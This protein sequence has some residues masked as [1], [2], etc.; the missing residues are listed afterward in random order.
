VHER[1]ALA[2]QAA[3]LVE[4]V[5][6]PLAGVLWTEG[7]QLSPE[8]LPPRERLDAIRTAADSALRAV[9]IEEGLFGDADPRTAASH[10]RLA[11]AR[12]I[13]RDID[14]NLD[15]TKA[16]PIQERG[17]RALTAA[18]ALGGDS[19]QI[20]KVKNNLAMLYMSRR[21][22]PTPSD[23]ARSVEL[24]Q[25]ALEGHRQSHGDTH[26]LF[27]N[28]LGNL[29]ATESRLQ[30]KDQAQARESI[31]LAEEALQRARE[32]GVARHQLLPLIMALGTLY[33]EYEGGDQGANAG[34]AIELGEEALGISDAH[35]GQ[36]SESG[37]RVRNNLGNAYRWDP[38]SPVR[39]IAVL[40]DA[41]AIAATIWGPDGAPVRVQ[42]LDSLA[43]AYAQAAAER[44]GP[45]GALERA[46][47]LHSSAV[48]DARTWFG[49]SDPRVADVLMD[50]AITLFHVGVARQKDEAILLLEDAIGIRRVAGGSDFELANLHLLLA[51]AH[52]KSTSTDVESALRAASE[53]LHVFTASTAPGRVL[54]LAAMLG[55]R[56]GNSG[57]WE[58]AAHFFATAQASAL[59]LQESSVLMRS[60]SDDT[61]TA[62]DTALA[63]AFAHTMAGLDTDAL[64][65]LERH[66]ARWLRDALLRDR[67]DLGLLASIA[68]EVAQR[69]RA[70]TKTLQSLRRHELSSTG[71]ITRPAPQRSDEPAIAG[72]V[73]QRLYRAAAAAQ[74]TFQNA[75]ADVRAIQGFEEFLAPATCA[76]L[77]QALA[78][79]WPA[80][81]LAPAPWGT[82]ILILWPDGCVHSFRAP[83]THAHV[84]EL[85]AGKQV[86]S[87]PIREGYVLVGLSA[88][89]TV[90]ADEKCGM[91]WWSSLTPTSSWCW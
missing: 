30:T 32:E 80:V 28:T 91:L 85:L 20:P 47:E 9:R 87:S 14:P 15:V 71:N 69:F 45:P 43:N 51:V 48:Q 38:G 36:E 21:P 58:E 46:L 55:N 29:V 4:N 78:P 13:Q 63:G 88:S 27:F 37:I 73:S 81:Y 10:W 57:R 82:V 8:Q 16:I 89:R 19:S 41:L 90:S 35:Y 31:V 83:V 1:A 49:D 61:F 53:A 77:T 75:L 54:G 67:A 64:L 86:G 17:L 52:L 59:A 5:D 25:E 84:A 72:P 65:C 2:R 60:H 39:A 40:E 62:G 7:A 34:R 24:L 42:L 44:D 23:L 18:A 68:P 50:H 56:L 70:A 6:A 11:R 22:E 26:G 79:G 66:R 3:A 33:L 12:G 74:R 76:Q